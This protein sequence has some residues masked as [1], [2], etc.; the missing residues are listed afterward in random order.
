[1][2]SRLRPFG[3]IFMMALLLPPAVSAGWVVNE[4]MVNEPGS[5]TSLE[6]VELYNPDENSASLVY[7]VLTID[8]AVD[9]A[10]LSGS[11]E[12]GG[13]TVI[14]KKLL[15]TTE[16]PGFENIWGNA[17]GVWGD[18]PGEDYEVLERGGFS[19]S[20]TGG[21]AELY[22][23][24]N[25]KS[26]L[27]WSGAGPDGV[28]WERLTP[29]QDLVA[30]CEDPDGATPGRENSVSPKASD[31]EL[32]PVTV[33][34]ADESNTALILPVA[35]IGINTVQQDSL[36]LFYDP[37]QDS[38]V[39]RADL[40]AV[41]DL[42]DIAPAETLAVELLAE[43]DGIYA[44][45]LAKLFS[46]DNNANNTQLFTAPGRDFP[47]LILNEF[48]ADPRA[49]LATEWVELKN[50]S[51]ETVDLNGWYLG[52][53]LSLHPIADQLLTVA[54]GEYAV[55]CRDSLD[56]ID[57]YGQADFILREPN[58]WPSLNNGSDKIR[59]IDNYAFPADS[60]YYDSAFGDNVT[61]GRGE[62]AGY[63]DRWGP[64]ADT[65]G[66][67]GQENNIYYPPTASRIE[68]TTT[69]NPFSPSVDGQMI[70]DFSLPSG[71]FGLK[72]YDYEGR[73][74]KNFYNGFAAF[75]GAVTWD[76]SSDGGRRLAPGIYILYLEIVDGESFK[77][78]VVIAP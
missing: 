15:G 43:L 10:L 76:G 30:V 9:V 34:P 31:L 58:G 18:D 73:V 67:P 11:I 75:D 23:F 17:S 28:S 42:P 19:L 51:S 50:V 69:P 33:W 8:D 63:T 56:F 60:L 55:L 48:M 65:G 3:L 64:S 20:N 21:K 13:Y 27:S 45:L 26:T 61:W 29:D 32:L 57:F 49:P 2:V 39:N 4:L 36:F 1:M 62:I 44:D 59:L 6:W 14:C 40:I 41:V 78:T 71:L 47:P 46:D 5:N 68:L 38:L 22:Y 72:I 12:P 53:S 77:Q 37:E 16:N 25:L 54:A 52:D 7:A 66:T 70:I 24:G 74:V 35:N